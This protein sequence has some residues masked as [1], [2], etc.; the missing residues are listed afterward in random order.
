M[1]RDNGF[2]IGGASGKSDN[3]WHIGIQPRGQCSYLRA[4]FQA[5]GGYLDV[6]LVK[7]WP[8]HI[9]LQVI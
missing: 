2:K 5:Y 1:C 8:T 4:S 3:L 6:L 9:S 7:R